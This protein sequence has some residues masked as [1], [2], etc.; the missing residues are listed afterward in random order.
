MPSPD[1][2]RAITAAAEKAL[3]V[4]GTY[5]KDLV[6]FRLKKKYE[7]GLEVVTLEPEKFHETLLGI[8]GAHATKV[9]EQLILKTLLPEMNLSASASTFSQTVRAI[10]R[11]E[12]MIAPKRLPPLC[13]VEK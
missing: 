13:K 4:C 12:L 11:G 9:L 2:D 7:M 10:R 3:D 8:A 5:F 1:I 6:A